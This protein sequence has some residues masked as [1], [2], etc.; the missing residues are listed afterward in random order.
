MVLIQISD[1]TATKIGQVQNGG[2]LIAYQ[3]A[4]NG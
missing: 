2:T 3:D 4:L 1:K